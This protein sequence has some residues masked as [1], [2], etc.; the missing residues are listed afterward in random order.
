MINDVYILE[1]KTQ[2]LAKDNWRGFSRYDLVFTSSI[3]NK[4]PKVE[5]TFI[6]DPSDKSFDESYVI[7][8]RYEFDL[9]S[10]LKPKSQTAAAIC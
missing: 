10:G 9:T 6:I 3:F 8:K 1:R 5:L 7:G 4:L 2:S